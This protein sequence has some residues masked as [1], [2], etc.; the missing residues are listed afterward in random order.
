[1]PPVPEA[2]RG[3]SNVL[4]AVKATRDRIFD[5]VLLSYEHLGDGWLIAAGTLRHSTEGGWMADGRKAALAHVVGGKCA[6][7]SR[8]PDGRG[9]SRRVRGAAVGRSRPIV[10]VRAGLNHV[11]VRVDDLDA[12]IGFYAEGFGLELIPAPSFGSPVVW[13]RAGSLQLHLTETRTPQPSPGHFALEVD[14]FGAVYRWAMTAGVLSRSATATRCSSCR[15][16][17]ARCT[18]TI[19]AATSSRSATPTPRVARGDP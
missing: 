6:R 9:G 14:D 1:M 15:A 18:S 12:A 2:M 17:S 3:K 7:E 19:R 4:E 11:G 10:T 16:A 5:P 13:L 8:L